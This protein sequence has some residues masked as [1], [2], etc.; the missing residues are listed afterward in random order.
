M[1]SIG[2]EYDD[3]SHE[4]WGVSI[5]VDADLVPVS[6]VPIIQQT[7]DAIFMV[8]QNTLFD[9]DTLRQNG[10]TL[11]VLRHEPF[12]NETIGIGFDDEN[13]SSFCATGI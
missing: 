7:F 1:Y 5:F 12:D 2:A 10:W 6:G 11:G 9:I 8:R 4:G 3:G 13:S